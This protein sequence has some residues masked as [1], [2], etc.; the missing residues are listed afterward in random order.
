MDVVIGIGRQR[1]R[2]VRQA[3]LDRLLARSAG[4][5]LHQPARTDAADRGAV[6]L[7]FLPRDGVDHRPVGRLVRR[8]LDHREGDRGVIRQ[9]VLQRATPCHHAEIGPADDAREFARQRVVT[10]GLG[11]DGDL[12]DEEAL[13]LPAPV[14][15]EILRRAHHLSIVERLARRRIDRAGQRCRGRGQQQAE[16]LD[17]QLAVEQIAI[18]RRA[19][20]IG[21]RIDGLPGSL[22]RAPGPII[23]LRLRLRRLRSARIAIVHADRIAWPTRFHRGL[24]GQP[25]EAGI[26]VALGQWGFR[27]VGPGGVRVIDLA[28]D[29]ICQRQLP[30]IR[31]FARVGQQH[32]EPAPDIARTIDQQARAGEQRPCRR[33]RR[34]ITQPHR[35]IGEETG[36]IRACRF[37]SRGQRCGLRGIHPKRQPCLEHRSFERADEK[38]LSLRRLQ[39]VLPQQFVHPGVLI[40]RAESGGEI[41]L[42]LGLVARRERTR[43]PR[44][45]R[46]RI[47]FIAQTA[48]RQRA[49]E[50]RTARAGARREP[51]EERD[52]RR[53]RRTALGQR[54]LRG[55]AQPRFAG[56]TGMREQ[57]PGII[58]ERIARRFA[59]SLP[60]HHRRR[61]AGILRRGL[62]LDHLLHAAPAELFLPRGHHPSG[63]SEHQGG[64]EQR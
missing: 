40:E 61:Q 48:H 56:P 5:Q 60:F 28:G 63:G 31:G 34:T 37:H 32:V 59:Q 38:H 55:I 57:E 16:P 53:R 10:V 8:H 44:L 58:L 39:R 6:E 21:S 13:V 9:P 2:I 26:I 30:V 3:K 14:R 29:R 64:F 22:R 45:A 49:R 35:A 36:V 42:Q 27:H 4:H 23:P 25:D 15:P 46:R 54:A 33:S 1:A 51:A 12:A 7:A 50:R 52:D 24:P 47:G 20:E 17:R 19:G 18:A 41:G 62:T 43:N 11:I